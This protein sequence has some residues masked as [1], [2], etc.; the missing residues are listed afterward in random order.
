MANAVEVWESLFR[1]QV[2]VMR[3]R[4]DG[5]VTCVP[6]LTFVDGRGIRGPGHDRLRE[7]LA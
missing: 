1:A 7:V 2:A 6:A 4:P 3:R 5:V